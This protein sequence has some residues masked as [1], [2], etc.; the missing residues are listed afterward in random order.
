MKTLLLKETEIGKAAS[1]LALGELVAFPTETVYGLGAPL[2]DEETIRKLFEVK[3]RPADNP[4]IAH[5]GDLSQL[6]SLVEEI[7]PLVEKLAAKFWPGPLTLVL[8]RKASVPSSVSAGLS[9]IA[10]RIPSHPLARK[11]IQD[12]GQPL[13]A[14]SAN[15]SG[16]PSP[17]TAADVLEDL[18]GKIAAV[19]DGG[20]CSLGLESTVLSLVHSTPKLLRP[21]TLSR[22]E[23]EECIGISLALPTKGDLSSSPGM[24]YRHYAPKAA[25]LLFEDEGEAALFAQKEK[26]YFLKPTASSLYA[27]LREADRLGHGSIAVYCNS[28]ILKDEAIMNRLHR[29]THD[30]KSH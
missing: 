22:K 27:E 6:S 24:K 11:L 14:P 18:D 17:T 19:I 13:V 29:I 2:F 9:T 15:L 20:P 4:L 10:V 8:K 16:R 30:T 7:P 1:L 26:G 5:I 21:G 25:V 3:G 12:L 23:I 28:A